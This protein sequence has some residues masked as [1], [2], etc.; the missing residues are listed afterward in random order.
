MAKKVNFSYYYSENVKR[1]AFSADTKDYSNEMYILHIA[2]G[3]TFYITM[4]EYEI[5]NSI[6]NENLCFYTPEDYSQPIPFV[7]AKNCLPSNTI[8]LP[9]EEFDIIRLNKEKLE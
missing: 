6:S 4:S 3:A 8:P 9:K 1:C 5:I 2:S 7:A